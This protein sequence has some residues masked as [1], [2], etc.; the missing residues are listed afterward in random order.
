MPGLIAQPNHGA[1]IVL[2]HRFFG[3]SNPYPDL[4]SSSLA[5]HTIDQAI[6]DLAYFA[7]NV[8]LPFPKDVE[9][10]SNVK[11]QTNPWVSGSIPILVVDKM[12]HV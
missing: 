1:T 9:D 3:L 11:P 4:S 7:T 5:V 6:E 2:E 8:H 10:G 12:P